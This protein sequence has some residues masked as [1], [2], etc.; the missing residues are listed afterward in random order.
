[1]RRYLLLGLVGLAVLVLPLWAVAQPM[2]VFDGCTILDSGS[3]WKDHV[4]FVFHAQAGTDSV[5]DIH[6]CVYDQDGNAVAV[7]A[8]SYE[9]CWTGHFTP[10]D[11]CVDYWSTGVAIAPGGTYGAFDLIMPPGNCVIT[12]VW[13]F[14]YDNVPVTDPQTVVWNCPYTAVT[15]DTWGLIKAL[16]R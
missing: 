16:Y 13:W 1:M 2:L 9:G 8:I 14:T 6:L 4:K 7:T 3:P 12:V 5:N 10:G 11:N 15:S